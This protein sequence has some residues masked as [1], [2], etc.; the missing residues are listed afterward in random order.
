MISKYVI[1]GLGAGIII[2][3]LALAAAGNAY[4]GQRDENVALNMKI[5]IA[6][7]T[8]EA[9]EE[10]EKAIKDLRAEYDGL[11]ETTEIAHRDEINELSTLYL[12]A[13]NDAR[14]KPVEFGDDLIRDFIRL[15]CM[16]AL[17]VAGAS[18]EGRATCS[19][20]AASAD[21]SRSGLSFTTINPDFLAGWRDACEDWKYVR[22]GTGDLAYT[23]ADWIEEY[24]NF[25]PLLCR[26]T[27]VAFTPEASIAL[28]QFILNGQNYSAQLLNYAV[29]Q[30][31]VIDAITQ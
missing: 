1:A 14:Q 6:R 8:Q 22:P 2:L 23:E 24:N 5:E 28:R 20:E 9:K 11:I 25:D 21:P 3:T 17:G 16:W 12:T 26:E 19:D 30:N 7:V 18:A 29:E 10:K 13:Q 27:L 15:D 4:L 31:A